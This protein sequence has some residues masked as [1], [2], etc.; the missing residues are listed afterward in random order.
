MSPELI[1]MGKK[2]V[3]QYPF[4]LTGDQSH[5]DGTVLYRQAG[6]PDPCVVWHAV[7]RFQG[8]DDDSGLSD[9]G[10]GMDLWESR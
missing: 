1:K 2:H 6:N 4:T 9:Q 7:Q 10:L 5:L 8:D 3:I